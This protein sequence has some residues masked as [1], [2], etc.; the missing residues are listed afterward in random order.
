[1][2]YVINFNNGA[3]PYPQEFEELEE[4]KA[5][6]MDMAGYTQAN[7]DILGH[8]GEIVAFSEWVGM[9]PS[10]IE[11]EMGAIMVRF[12]TSGYYRIWSDELEFLN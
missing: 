9:Q 8:N 11:K 1:M 10:R 4:A 2:S 3:G 6:A 12:G 5:A 7:I